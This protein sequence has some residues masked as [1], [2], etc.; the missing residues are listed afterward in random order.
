MRF[1]RAAANVV[2]AVVLTGCAAAAPYQLYQSTDAAVLTSKSDAAVRGLVQ[3]KLDVP[4]SFG[5]PSLSEALVVSVDGEIGKSTM[6]YI[7][8]TF[9]SAVNGQFTI[10]V[11]PGKHTMVLLPNYHLANPKDTV[12][13][14]IQAQAGHEYFIG[15]VLDITKNPVTIAGFYL[16]R[17]QY[18]WVPVVVDK[19]E[20]KL[21]YPFI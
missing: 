5:G 6:P 9:N 7:G 11:S 19:T 14:E 20:M 15:C 17:G 18:R 4:F 2:C 21:I 10:H 12:D 8:R 1:L 16:V 3:D 13:V